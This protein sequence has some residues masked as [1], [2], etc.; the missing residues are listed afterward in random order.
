MIGSW[1]SSGDRQ[2]Q[3]LG[4][5]CYQGGTDTSALMENF[6]LNLRAMVRTLRG[7]RIAMLGLSADRQ[8][9]GS[10]DSSA[11]Y[12]AQRILDAGCTVVAYDAQ[13]KAHAVTVLSHPRFSWSDDPYEAMNGA[14]AI[15]A[16]TD[17]P[18]CRNLDLVAAKHR[19]RR[20]IL[21]DAGP[22]LSATAVRAAGFQYAAPEATNCREAISLPATL[23]PGF[24]AALAS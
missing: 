7:K 12:M 5:H 20:P 6:F 3:G 23:P 18:V 17:G 19:V 1:T 21:A 22:F 24:H 14:D 15:V 16:M 2:Q 8:P 4:R 11:L 9:A 10:I 13:V